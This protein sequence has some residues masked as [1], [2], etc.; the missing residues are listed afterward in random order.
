MLYENLYSRRGWCVLPVCLN[1]V[2]SG[3]A[4][5][6]LWWKSSGIRVGVLKRRASISPLGQ[7]RRSVGW[8]P[9]IGAQRIS[10]EQKSGRLDEGPRPP[11]CVC[12]VRRKELSQLELAG[13]HVPG[14]RSEGQV[15]CEGQAQSMEHCEDVTD[16]KEVGGMRGAVI[17]L[18]DI[19]SLEGGNMLECALSVRAQKTPEKEDAELVRPQRDL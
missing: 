12:S 5:N 17:I 14:A 18:Q 19:L 2:P 8:C 9:S 3:G 10:A 4:K 6:W 1:A 11:L 7:W 13:K 16:G 15:R